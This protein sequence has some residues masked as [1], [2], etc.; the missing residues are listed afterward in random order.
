MVL[1][2]VYEQ[3]FLPCSFGFRPGRSAHQ[4]LE[5]FQQQAMKMGGGWV[6]EVDIRKFFDTLG[7]EHLREIIRHR[8]GDGVLLRMIGKWLNAGV[9]EAGCLSYPEEGS[10][11]GGVISPLLANVYL[12]EVL[13]TWFEQ[14]VKAKLKGS[15]HLTRY[16]DDAVLL[17]EEESDARRVMEV[18]PKRFGKYGLTLH[19]EKTRLVRFVRPTR[20]DPPDKGDRSGTFDLLGFTHFW[21][22]SRKGYWVVKR[23]TA[24]S[25]FSRG[26]KAL[27]HWCCKNR[28]LSIKEQWRTLRQKLNG[29]Y[30]YYG[31]TG[32]SRALGRFG[33]WAAG[34]WRKWLCRRSQRAYLTWEAF[35]RLLAHYPLPAPTIR[36][37]FAPSA[38]VT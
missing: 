23:K 10:P 4:A 27:A 2:S 26:L 19:P 29:H 6:L 25:R 31:I 11:Q 1:E 14:T 35:G 7:H 33:F 22:M 18:L 8:I 36:R 17:F 12:H 9:Q 16:A 30:G 13:D 15:A 38:S 20:K 3:D 34:I 32:N 37:R 28:H 21:A 5:V 24:S